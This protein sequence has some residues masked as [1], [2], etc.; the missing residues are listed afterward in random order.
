MVPVWTC[1]INR[2][3]TEDKVESIAERW[4][5]RYNLPPAVGSSA[6][7]LDSTVSCPL[8]LYEHMK[9]YEALNNRSLSPWRYVRVH[10][11]DHYPET[12]VE[13]QCLCSGCIIFE[14]DIPVENDTYNSVPVI[15]SKTFLK[16]KLCPNKKTYS[17]EPVSVNVAVGCTCAIANTSS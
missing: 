8:A 13:A 15:Q 17:L 9:P 12:Y 4:L 3:L 7:T 1:K 16:K 2:C 14:N 10:K 5:K 11:K 6:A